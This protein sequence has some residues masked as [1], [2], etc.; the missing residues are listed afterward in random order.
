MKLLSRFL[1]F[2]APKPAEPLDP[3]DDV[4]RVNDEL[5]RRAARFVATFNALFDD[6]LPEPVAE[7]ADVF[8]E[9]ADEDAVI[10]RCICIGR[11]AD[12]E[13][14]YHRGIRRGPDGRA[15]VE[16]FWDS[17]LWRTKQYSTRDRS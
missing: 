12:P 17:Q 10:G 6:D 13:R 7:N 4:W 15:G 14:F 8:F 16:E 11:T 3:E 2:L 1:R 9:A 5:A